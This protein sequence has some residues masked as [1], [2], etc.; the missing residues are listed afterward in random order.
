MRRR[1]KEQRGGVT[2]FSCLVSRI[3]FNAGTFHDGF[4][5]YC[6]THNLSF[7]LFMSPFSENLISIRIQLNME[8]GLIISKLLATG[9][10][11]VI[12]SWETPRKI[13]S[14]GQERRSHNSDFRD[15]HEFIQKQVAGVQQVQHS[16]R[17]DSIKL[18]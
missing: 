8:T 12:R 17:F 18:G 13:I 9:D 7:K 15:F 3:S 5:N 4:V 1:G 14:S 10:Q 2:T 11:I 16:R 6:K